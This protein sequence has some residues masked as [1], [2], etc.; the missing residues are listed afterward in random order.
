ME[1]PERQAALQ[2]YLLPDERILWT[3]RPGSRRW[4]TAADIYLV[5]FSLFWGG[6]AL[7]WEGLVLTSGA[8]WPFALW[9][10]PFIVIGQYLIWGRFLYKRWD[11]ARTT[12]AVTSRRL[13]VL[14]GGR[15]QSL[16]LNQ[17]PV[18]NQSSGRDASGTLIFG[19]AP[20][21]YALWANTGLGWFYQH[22]AP[23]TFDDIP[24]VNIVY[25]LVASAAAR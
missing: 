11:R 5:P 23:L 7:F 10:I 25:G 13:V 9:G 2:P 17:L 18:V 14:K 8:P 16:F 4:F 19:S 6:F 22:A 20:S 1:E 15:P 3:G 21:G 12:Y 24:D